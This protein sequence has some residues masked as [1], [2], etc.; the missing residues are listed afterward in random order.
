MTPASAGQFAP[1]STPVM[2]LRQPTGWLYAFAMA[3]VC[4]AALFSAVLAI[5]HTVAPH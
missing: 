3:T 4:W 1:V 5:A 2:V